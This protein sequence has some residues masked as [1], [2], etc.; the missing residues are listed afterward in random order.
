MKKN[1]LAT[2]MLS[3]ALAMGFSVKEGGIK[4]LQDKLTALEKAEAKRQRK[5]LRKEFL[6]H[7]QKG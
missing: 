4:K 3:M 1:L 5:R 6:L 2:A 7:K